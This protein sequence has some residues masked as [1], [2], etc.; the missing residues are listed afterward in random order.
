VST[1]PPHAAPAKLS[2]GRALAIILLG[3]LVGGVVMFVWIFFAERLW[4]DPDVAKTVVAALVLYLAFGAMAGLL[5]ALASAALWTQVVGLVRGF[6]PRLLAAIAVGGVTGAALIWPFIAL[7][8]G[9]YGPDPWFAGPAALAG[10]VALVAT[11]LPG[12][13]E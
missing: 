3:P 5:P 10:A 13:K 6:W 11:A 9:P 12:A 2:W 1:P 4:T 8:F 7:V